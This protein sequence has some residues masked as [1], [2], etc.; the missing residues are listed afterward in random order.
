MYAG[1]AL[2]AVR[3]NGT[4]PWDSDVDIIISILDLDALKDA[5]KREIE[6]PLYLDT[7]PENPDCRIL[8][9]RLGVKGISIERVH[10]D[11]FLYSGMPNNDVHNYLV[12][13]DKLRKKF[14]S[15]CF[16]PSRT[17]NPVKRFVSTI[18]RLGKKILIVPSKSTIYKH[19][20]S[21]GITY[22]VNKSTVV[23]EIG[24]GR[25]W[26]KSV[27]PKSYWLDTIEWQY[28]EFHVKI[29]R[30]YDIMLKRLYGNY[31]EYP[32]IEEQ[33]K[34]KRIVFNATE[35]AYRWCEENNII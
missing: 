22:D 23:G 2:G 18:I 33:E 9:P 7:Y 30:E 17:A 12:G 5:C 4:I 6:N 32:P 15:K 35:E 1:S 31:M 21:Y 14:H 13:A 10:V 16:Q 28:D 3:H 26:E 11:I 25:A 19:F 27:F 34:I 20:T 8:F 24:C 29:P